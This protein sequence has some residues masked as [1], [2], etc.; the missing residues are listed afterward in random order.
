MLLDTQIPIGFVI[1]KIKYEL[2]FISIYATTINILDEYKFA[3]IAIPLALP[4]IV[5]TAITLNARSYRARRLFSFFFH[6]S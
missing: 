2:I 1:S 6:V 3:N 4:A 5:G